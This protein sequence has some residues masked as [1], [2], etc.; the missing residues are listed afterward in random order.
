MRSNRPGRRRALSMSQGWFVAASTNTPS[1]SAATESISERFW[2]TVLRMLLERQVRPL[3]AERV[4]LV[5]EQHAGGRRR[6]SA[7][8]RARLR[9]LWPV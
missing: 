7:K 2:L 5:E 9:S 6:A 1:L 8:I 4:E 3:L